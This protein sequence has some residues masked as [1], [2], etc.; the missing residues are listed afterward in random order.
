[1]RPYQGT[2]RRKITDSFS[3]EYNMYIQLGVAGL[4][5]LENYMVED[6]V[7]APNYSAVLEISSRL[8]STS[9]NG[10]KRTAE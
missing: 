5:A 4:R 3:V 7:S 9:R 10:A 2:A 6:R 8:T 1:M